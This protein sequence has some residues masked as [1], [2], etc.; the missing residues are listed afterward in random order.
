MSDI[1]YPYIPNTAPE[2]RNA[3]LAELGVKDVEELYRQVPERLRF[4]R[5][6][7]L[8]EPLLSES[9]LERHVRGLL[10]KNSTCNEYLSF[11]GAGCEQH[12][13]PAVVDAMIG[14]GEFLTAYLGNAYT[15]NGRF[16]AIF[17]YQSMLCD[18]LGMEIAG[19]PMT[20]GLAASGT[21]VRMAARITGRSEVLVPATINPRRL[22]QMKT[23]CR[24]SE[25][26][27]ITTVAYDRATGLLDLV[28]LKGKLDSGVA[29]VLVEN[30][31]YLGGVESQLEAIANLAHG[32][33]ALLVACVNPVS[34]GILPNPGDYDADIA[35]GD[36]QPLGVHMN[37]GGGTTGFVATKDIP[38]HI[39]EFPGLIVNIAPTLAGDGFGFTMWGYAERLHYMARELGKEYTGTNAANW[40]IANAVYL[41]LMGPEGMR[42][43]GETIVK[44]SHYAK[45]LVSEI[46]GL[47]LP[48]SAP[49][50]NEFVVNFD[51]TGRSVQQVN[52][53]L[54]E[55]KIFG[56]VDLSEVFPDLGQSALYCVSEIHTASDVKELAS[57]LREVTR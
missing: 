18:L 1:V 38:E 16:Q 22:E 54:L 28:D 27:T 40:A 21:A 35:C 10:E 41:S 20:C 47:A 3:M 39:A 4:R 9:D 2:T 23:Y 15:D 48:L 34:L 43:I 36:S 6:L 49:H 52:E 31:S 37:Y 30:P 17:E 29:C 50:F 57:A 51:K 42:E 11:L 55:Q 53:A 7:D 25:V 45:K 24:Y 5:R 13:V 14:R 44:K 12:Y 46:P 56:G 8:P 32:A 33:G 19:F 26:G